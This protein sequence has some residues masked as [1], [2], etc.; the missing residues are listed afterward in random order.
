MI[1]LVLLA[2]IESVALGMPRGTDF[3]NQDGIQL[4]FTSRPSEPVESGLVTSCFWPA[5]NS[6]STKHQLKSTKTPRF[7]ECFCRNER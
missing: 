3:R 1:V 6:P 5:Y 2:W 7:W 4:H